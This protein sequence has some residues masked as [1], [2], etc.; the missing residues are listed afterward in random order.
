MVY[1]IFK[2]YVACFRKRSIVGV[3]KERVNTWFF[4]TAFDCFASRKKISS[5]YFTS[6]LYTVKLVKSVVLYLFGLVLETSYFWRGEIVVVL[7]LVHTPYAL[8]MRA[9]PGP[10]CENNILM[11]LCPPKMKCHQFL[12]WI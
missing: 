2:S 12:E 10:K 8:L 4:L 6:G 7:L 1:L 5:N 9:V 11:Q 3:N